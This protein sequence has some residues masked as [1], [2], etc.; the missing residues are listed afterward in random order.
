MTIFLDV[1]KTI[2]REKITTI[3]GASIGSD[4]S[5]LYSTLSYIG[6]SRDLS[7]SSNKRELLTGLTKTIDELVDQANDKITLD[8]VKQLIHDCLEKVQR[9]ARMAGQPRGTTENELERLSTILESS[10]RAINELKICNIPHDADPLN[11][12]RYYVAL[13]F[14]RNIIK[15]E[16]PT[17][18]ESLKAHLKPLS[19]ASFL[20]KQEELVTNTLIQC[21]KNIDALAPSHP[22]YL[23][24]KKAFVLS[25]ID[26]LSRTNAEEASKNS[27]LRL[28]FF[29]SYILPDDHILVRCLHEA[30]TEIDPAEFVIT[31]ETADLA[32]H[33]SDVT[34]THRPLVEEGA[35]AGTTEVNDR[36][37]TEAPAPSP[38]LNQTSTAP[39][40]KQQKRTGGKAATSLGG[41]TRP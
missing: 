36:A 29:G 17:T 38:T 5:S 31:E 30:L 11:I 34:L 21:T 14:T 41:G 8:L 26:I 25:Q 39:L 15:H 40:S 7:L 13:Y 3:N 24:S 1:T 32:P 6:L 19:D 27:K 35:L 12:F 2:M 4:E 18:L 33:G 22:H 28:G 37:P 16:T 23:A 10:Y 9:A 20:L